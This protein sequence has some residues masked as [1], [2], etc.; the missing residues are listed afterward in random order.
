MIFISALK[1]LLII[2]VRSFYFYSIF[3][4]YSHCRCAILFYFSVSLLIILKWRS[5][6]FTAPQSKKRMTPNYMLIM[7]EGWWLVRYATLVN[8]YMIWKSWE[9]TCP[10]YYKNSCITSTSLGCMSLIY[11]FLTSSVSWFWLSNAGI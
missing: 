6:L 8:R 2:R 1:V 3:N 9:A 5:Y 7:L 11:E 4:I 10:T